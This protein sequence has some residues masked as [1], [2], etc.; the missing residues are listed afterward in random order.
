MVLSWDDPGDGSITGYQILRRS[1][2]RDEYGDGQ[3][4]PEFV[5][6]VDDT[7][8]A[9]TTDTDSSLTARTKYVY[10]AKAIN[11]S[12]LSAQS[13]YV[14]VETPPP[15]LPGSTPARTDS[16]HGACSGIIR[17]RQ[18]DAGLGRSRGQ[19]L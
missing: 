2:D 6:I 17:P 13:S 14:N 12:G 8:S 19:L 1:R 7:G 4:A 10:R 18:C 3:G 11:A 9:S 16:A 5:A 15:P